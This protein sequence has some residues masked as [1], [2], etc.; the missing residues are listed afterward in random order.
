MA[1]QW[2]TLTYV[3]ANGEPQTLFNLQAEGCASIE[4]AQGYLGA[5]DFKREPQPHHYTDL[6]I[7]IIRG[8]RCDIGK[9]VRSDC[10]KARTTCRPDWAPKRPWITYQHGEAGPHFSG[11]L[12]A[13]NFLEGKGFK[14]TQYRAKLG[15]AA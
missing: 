7:D 3:Y 8:P 5:T 9:T 1:V 4:R 6:E 13:V 2:F 12:A 11:P 10:G 15:A 14:F